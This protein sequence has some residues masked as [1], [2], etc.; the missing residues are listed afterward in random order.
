[1]LYKNVKAGQT[2]L[3]LLPDD[4]KKN[5]VC[6]SSNHHFVSLNKEIAKDGD[7]EIEYYGL[8]HFWGSKIYE[9]SLRYL[10]A[11]ALK[12]ISPKNE[13]RFYYNV[14]RTLFCKS[15][16]KNF[17]VTSSFIDELNET[18]DKLIKLDIPF[19][20]KRISK[21]EAN[22]IYAKLG[23]KDKSKVFK[24]RKESYVHFYQAKYNDF[25]YS[26]Y[27][28]S[29]LV[30]SSGYLKTFKIKAY[31]PGFVIQLPRS[32]CQG[33][34]P[35]FIDERKYAKTLQSSSH[36]QES[37]SLDTLSNIN[38]FLRTYSPMELINVCE[39]RFNN[40]M[41]E[42][43]KKIV[44]VEEPIRLICI[45]GPSSSGKTSFS[46]RLIFELM[47]KGLKPIRISMDDY[48]I[49]FNQLKPNTSLESIDALDVELFDKQMDALIHGE[50]VQIP[51]YDFKTHDRK[52]GKSI[53]LNE[54]QP[55]IIEGIHALN[56]LICQ[57]IP[58]AQ[59]YKIYIAP[60]SQINVDNHTP[61]SMTEMRLLRRI[62]RDIRTR[63]TSASKTIEMWP[64]VREGE[65]KYIYPTEENANFIFDTFMP[66]E[67]NV[68]RNIVMPELDK[69]SFE[70][71][72]YQL[73]I[74]LKNIIK[75]CLPIDGE[76]IPC[77]SLIREFVGGSSFK[78]AR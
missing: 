14:S 23:F 5:Y 31:Y 46:N 48:F 8:D 60:H 11:M 71:E 51:I 25:V 75:Y 10:I 27:M 35:E 38:A 30:P 1:M 20:F 2:Y 17:V 6:A 24:Y 16:N 52:F 21:E 44:E 32:E 77:N 55:I 15:I 67:L 57:N 72:G 34:I 4:K 39:A 40:M 33:D 19:E 76:D 47:A 42:L 64:S 13:F 68:L 3:D 70:E 61:V 49:P 45:A 50:S 59:K 12:I 37:L 41:A 66:Y 9:A 74:R 78:D 54:N 58:A 62:A 73:A 26:D 28:Y 36:W 56:N 43:G 69:I 22:K 65:F 53:I 7:Y 29:L 18:L 63:N